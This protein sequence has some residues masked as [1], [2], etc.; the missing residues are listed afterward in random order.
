MKLFRNKKGF[1][2]IELTILIAVIGAVSY[3]AAPSVGKAV[4]NIFQGDKNSQKQIHKVKESYPV[5]YRASVG[6]DGIATYKP[7]GDYKRNEEFYNLKAQ[8]PPETLWQKFW[9]LGAMAVVIIIA[10]S[11]LGLW[12]IIALWWNKK[13]KPKIEQ[14]RENLKNLQKEKFELTGQAE[15]IVVSVDAGLKTLKD[16]RE[17]VL[18]SSVSA[19]DPKTKEI[20]S[21]VAQA[22]EKAHKDFLLAMKTKQDSDTED[23]VTDLLKHD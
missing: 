14:T 1:T 16:S 3:F 15:Q 13:I 23:L 22:L 6:K 18:A 21:A 8:K 7:A 17:N 4:H 2:G 10:L 12:P 5:L 11:Y 9:K 19:T 20:Y